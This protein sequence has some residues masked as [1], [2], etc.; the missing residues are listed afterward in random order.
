MQCASLRHLDL[1]RLIENSGITAKQRFVIDQ[2][3]QG[4]T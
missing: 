2:T 3:M 1:D 4:W